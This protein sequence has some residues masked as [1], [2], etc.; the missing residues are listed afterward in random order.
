MAIDKF[1][2]EYESLHQV[3]LVVDRRI[4]ETEP[5]RSGELEDSIART[6]LLK[7]S[8]LR[9]NQ[10]C[11]FSVVIQIPYF[12]PN[13][14]MEQKLLLHKKEIYMYEK[15]LPTMYESWTQEKLS[16]NYYAHESQSGIL[17]L[18]NLYQ[19][20]LFKMSETSFS[21][22]ECKVVLKCL[23]QF[24]A[25]STVHL[26]KV[27]SVLDSLTVTDRAPI[28]GEAET[29]IVFE[30]FRKFSFPLI[31]NEEMKKAIDKIFT[32]YRFLMNLAFLPNLNRLNVI[33]H[34]NVR[35]SNLYFQNDDE[36]NA[37]VKFKFVDFRNSRRGSPAIDL[38]HFLTTSAQF[39]VFIKHRNFL[40]E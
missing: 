24:H 29:N 17:I 2:K 28:I 4:E 32:N 35:W 7:F 39:E 37:V 21:F 26:D 31:I 5:P 15:V 10:N 30:K 20:G 23:A 36:D 38:V 12:R 34:G 3:T 14:T 16:P 33:I 6:F 18:E 11:Y 25:L 8:F 27:L 9:N 1:I 13:Y 19:E 40:F 22:P